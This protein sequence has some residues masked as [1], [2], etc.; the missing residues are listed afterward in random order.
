M[1]I[2]IILF[3][4]GLLIPFELNAN[5]ESKEKVIT[6]YANVSL[7][8]PYDGMLEV[9][10]KEFDDFS[11]AEVNFSRTDGKKL[12]IDGKTLLNKK[13]LKLLKL[14]IT[15]QRF[16]DLPKH[17]VPTEYNFHTPIYDLKVCLGNK[18]HEVTLDD[19]TMTMNKREY[20]RFKT[21]WDLVMNSMPKWPSD[22]PIMPEKEE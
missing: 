2:T 11:G 6:I 16:F 14:N 4:L 9:D 5:D 3:I 17:I 7:V 12:S 18:C 15:K 1:K 13:E 21:I 20:I 10:I 19:P 8:G 22:W